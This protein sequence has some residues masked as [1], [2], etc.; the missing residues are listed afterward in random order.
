MII[1]IPVNDD[2]AQCAIAAEIPLLADLRGAF[3]FQQTNRIIGRNQIPYAFAVRQDQQLPVRIRLALEARDR[4]R[5]PLAA[6]PRDAQA[7][8]ETGAAGP[9]RELLER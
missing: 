2:L 8:H 6:I 1:I 4:F 3:E 7:R 9:P 5:D